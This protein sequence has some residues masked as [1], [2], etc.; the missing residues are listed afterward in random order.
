MALLRLAKTFLPEHRTDVLPRSVN[1]IG[2]TPLDLTHQRNVDVLR[3]VLE[4]AGFT[5]CSDGLWVALWRRLA[6]V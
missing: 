1:L 2:A 6:A 5:V 3:K 4:D